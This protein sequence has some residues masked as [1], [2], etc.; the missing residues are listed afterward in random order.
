MATYTGVGRSNTFAVKDV[1][2]LAAVMEQYGVE[3]VDRGGNRVTLFADPAGDGS[4][5]QMRCDDDGDGTDDDL[6]HIPTLVAE[7]LLDGEVAVFDHCGAEKRRYLDA[8][9]TAVFSDG[10]TVSISLDDVYQAAA[11]EF[12][13][14]V[15]KISTA[16]Y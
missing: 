2:K 10:R 7:H 5:T 9:S 8:N 6:V 15:E 13:V 4:W 16:A 11:D 12:G 1:A 14:A 3:L